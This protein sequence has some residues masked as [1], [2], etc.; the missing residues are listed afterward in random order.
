MKYVDILSPGPGGAWGP[1]GGDWSVPR[2]SGGAW[3]V[4]VA[5]RRCPAA[6]ATAYGPSSPREHATRAQHHPKIYENQRK[7]LKINENQ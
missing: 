6:P 3:E 1:A 2:G 5:R 7:P 4:P